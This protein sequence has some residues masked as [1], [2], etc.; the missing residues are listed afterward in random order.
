MHGCTVATY[1]GNETKYYDLREADR[2]SVPLSRRISKQAVRL[3]ELRLW[4]SLV[5]DYQIDATK[6]FSQAIRDVPNLPNLSYRI[7]RGDSLLERLFGHVVQLDEM[8]KDA[9]SKQLIDSIQSD[10]HTYFR[11]DPVRRSGGWNWEFLAKQA[12][13]AE[14]LI[15]RQACG[16]TMCQKNLFGDEA[17][18][19]KERRAR[20]QA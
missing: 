6:P 9:K 11:E 14:R 20:E 1:L 4:L 3:C 8:A 2:G 19:A 7:V 15:D 5:V 13:L 12:D 18:T 16:L 17:M 10:K